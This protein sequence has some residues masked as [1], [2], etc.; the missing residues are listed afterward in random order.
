[1]GSVFVDTSAL[2]KYYYP[3]M[4]SEQVELQIVNADKVYLCQ[5]TPTE[6]ASA[7][8]KK[9]RDKTLDP[10]RQEA[11]WSVFLDD[12]SSL[13]VE[14]VPLTQRHFA[15]AT[16]MIR[17]YGHKEGIRTLDS[18]QLVTAL[19][20][21]KAKFLSADKSLAALAVKIGLSVEKI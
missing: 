1:V 12:L 11:I 20:V 19:E 14:L 5:L 15:K 6:F 2:V 18:L 10:D 9:V 8:M 4:G 21:E 13:Q 7:L 17:S 16:Q 3:E